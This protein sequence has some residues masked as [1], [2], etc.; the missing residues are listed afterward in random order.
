[1]TD[2]RRRYFNLKGISFTLTGDIEQAKGLVGYA[3]K[4]MFLT[5]L[6]NNN[7]IEQVVNHRRLKTGAE[8]KVG[9]NHGRKSANIYYPPAQIQEPIKKDEEIQEFWRFVPA[10]CIN[11]GAGKGS[12]QDEGKISVCTSA[13]WKGVR[14]VSPE[15]EYAYYPGEKNPENLFLGVKQLTQWGYVDWY[16]WADFV[17]TEDTLSDTGFSPFPYYGY[18][19]QDGGEDAAINAVAPVYY[20]LGGSYVCEDL[21]ELHNQWFTGNLPATGWT[22]VMSG[23]SWYIWN[24][25][26]CAAYNVTCCNEWHL[27]TKLFLSAQCGQ[28]HLMANIYCMKVN[29]VAFYDKDYLFG[30]C[31]GGQIDCSM[32]TQE[33]FNTTVG[34]AQHRIREENIREDYTFISDD[35]PR[36]DGLVSFSFNFHQLWYNKR[37]AFMTAP[38]ETNQ[39]DTYINNYIIPET[40]GF[41]GGYIHESC[42]N[43]DIVDDYFV[44]YIEEVWEES[45]VNTCSPWKASGYGYSSTGVY[46]HGWLNSCSG[47]GSGYNF[48]RRICANVLGERVVIDEAPPTDNGDTVFTCTDSKLYAVN[49]VPVFMYA[50]TSATATIIGTSFK[51]VVNYTRYGYF[52]GTFDNHYQS[53]KFYPIDGVASSLHDVFGSEEKGLYGWG[54]CAGYMINMKDGGVYGLQ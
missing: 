8:I 15:T 17:T 6:A 44:I 49:G 22:A 26:Y 43:K 41:C 1:M 11:N 28:G 52:K 14:W 21:E 34:S 9:I 54:Q 19:S 47:G 30:T 32:E 40:W 35:D 29:E 46:N 24:D 53:E 12:W 7:N 18:D 2:D 31:L 38:C 23:V 50:Y 16:F 27:W 5:D 51:W 33:L 20:Q 36:G 25:E 45:F 39:V 10:I 4:L 42:N 48:Y 13:D 37:E 3:S